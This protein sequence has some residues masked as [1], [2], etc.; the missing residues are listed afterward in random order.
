M[1][2]SVLPAACTWVG[3]EAV[4]DGLF[5]LAVLLLGVV[6]DGAAEEAVVVDPDVV[7]LSG[8]MYC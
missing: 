2:G 8:S 5:A 6:A 7:V 1:Y 3:A 4:A